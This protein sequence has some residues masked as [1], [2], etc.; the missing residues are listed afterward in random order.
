[1]NKKTILGVLLAASS[2]T[3]M[4]D[5]Y[6]YLTVAYNSIEQSIELATI[7]KIT[8]EDTNV[9]VYTSE[10]QVTFPQDEMEKMF[11]SITAT[12]IESL[13]QQSESLKVSNGVLN[14]T[15]NGLLHIYGSNGTLQR[16]AKIDGSANISLSNLPKGVYIVNIGKQTIKV[17][18]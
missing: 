9:V 15:G 18:K 17:T 6:Q 13:P 12:A 1:M 8:F 3:A 16:M 5:D 14:V 10:G 7:Q 11:F 4:A 2:M